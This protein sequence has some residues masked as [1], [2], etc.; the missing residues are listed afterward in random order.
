MTD[1]A[2]YQGKVAGTALR[3]ELLTPWVGWVSLGWSLLWLVFYWVVGIPAVILVFP[4]VFGIGLL[5]Y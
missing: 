4:L 2:A 5:L 1:F 3:G